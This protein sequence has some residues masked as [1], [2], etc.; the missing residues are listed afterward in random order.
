MNEPAQGQP[1]IWNDDSSY[2]VFAS[3]DVLYTYERSTGSAIEI[4]GVGDVRGMT[5][6]DA[7]FSVSNAET[8]QP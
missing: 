1:L 6:V 5:G 4:D 3:G 8:G 2:A 7:G